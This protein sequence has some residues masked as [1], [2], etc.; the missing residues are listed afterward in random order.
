LDDEE[1]GLVPWAL[2]AVTEKVYVVPLVS[3]PI[4]HIMAVVVHVDPSGAAVTS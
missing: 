1:A 4:S 3:P 2:V